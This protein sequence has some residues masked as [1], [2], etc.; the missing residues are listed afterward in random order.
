MPFAPAIL[1]EDVSDYLIDY[2]E[3]HVAAKYMTMTYKIKPQMIK[4]YRLLFMWM[5]LRGLRWCLK[6][7]ILVATA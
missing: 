7:T 5:K 3:D 4:K 2:R 6:K 1:A